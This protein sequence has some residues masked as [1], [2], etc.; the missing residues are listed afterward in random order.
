M[1]PC[2]LKFKTLFICISKDTTGYSNIQEEW[3]EVQSF[4]LVIVLTYI[5][6]QKFCKSKDMTQ[7]ISKDMSLREGGR[8]GRKDDRFKC[9]K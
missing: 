5:T 7:N 4:S 9:Q 6:S 3:S 8:G 1:Y 2:P